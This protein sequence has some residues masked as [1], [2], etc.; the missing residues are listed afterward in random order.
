MDIL[1][2]LLLFAILAVLIKCLTILVRMSALITK[3]KEEIIT[4]SV[5]LEELDFKN[6]ENVEYSRLH[7]GPPDIIYVVW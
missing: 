4:V 1:L 6:E 2:A 5:Q 3:L 7:D